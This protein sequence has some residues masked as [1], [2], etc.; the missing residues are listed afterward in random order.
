[1]K[2]RS[3]MSGNA[4]KKTLASLESSNKVTSFQVV[5]LLLSIFV[6]LSLLVEIMFKLPEEILQ[7]LLYIDVLICIVFFF[8][9]LQQYRSAPSKLEYMKWGWLDLISCIPLMEMNQYARVI[10][11]L[12]LIKTIKNISSLSHTI[13]ENRTSSSFHLMLFLSLMMMVFG[14]IYILY[15]E[16]GAVS[17][18]I[19]TASDAFWWTFV[20]ITT[21]GYGDL[22]PVTFEGRIVAMV[23]ITSG[24]GLFGSSTAL[25]ASWVLDSNKDSSTYILQKELDRLSQE[26]T[27]LKRQLSSAYPSA[28]GQET[29]H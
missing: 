1:M 26:N 7:I 2:S 23:L 27:E 11:I 20:T 17:A 15:L 21:V 13:S 24:V 18:N 9:F 10:R 5:V 25:L 8:D 14:S 3:T 16:K 19:H 12:R 28:S 22:Y 29:N 4:T 6:V